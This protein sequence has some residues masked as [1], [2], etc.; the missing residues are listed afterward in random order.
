MKTILKFAIVAACL[1]WACVA[2]LHAQSRAPRL[3]PDTDHAKWV[4]MCLRDFESIKVGMARAEIEGKL[5]QDGGL[6]SVSPFRFAHSACASFKI[7]VEFDFKRNP[8][9]QNRAVWGKGDK[10]TKVSKPYLERPFAD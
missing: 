3:Q 5:S 9:D 10:A 8:A 7:D 2:L 1:G 6:Q 4:E